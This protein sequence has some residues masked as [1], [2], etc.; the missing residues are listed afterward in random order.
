MKGKRK[1]QKKTKG[2]IRKHIVFVILF[3]HTHACIYR[4]YA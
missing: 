2:T 1:G 3:A 4:V